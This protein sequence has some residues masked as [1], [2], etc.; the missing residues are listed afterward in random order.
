MIQLKPRIALG[1]LSDLFNTG[2]AYGTEDK[3]NIVCLRCRGKD[4]TGIRPHQALQTHGRNT[5]WSIIGFTKKL[6]LLTRPGII[7]Q[8]IRL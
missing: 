2:C 4:L 8:V 1:D 7:P 6:S 5:K 3:G